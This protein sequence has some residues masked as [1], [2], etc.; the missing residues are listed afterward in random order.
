MVTDSLDDRIVESSLET[1][2]F[3]SINRNGIKLG[4]NRTSLWNFFDAEK[5]KFIPS[6]TLPGFESGLQITLP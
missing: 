6:G 4:E 5:A 3:V 1:D 2:G